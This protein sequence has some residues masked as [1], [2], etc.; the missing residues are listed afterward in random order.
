M[1]SARLPHR[2][3]VSVSGPEARAFLD[4]LLTCD[5]SSAAPGRSTF[6][7]LLSPQGKILADF[8]VHAP[9]PDTF[10]LD[11][12]A[13]CA[14]EL[15]KRLS[16]YRLRAK[17]A[18]E[19]LSSSMAVVA[20]WNGEPEPVVALAV[21]A[22][23]RLAELGWRA[24]VP[25]TDIESAAGSYD[26]HRIAQGVPE[27]GRD[28]AFAD[29]FPHEAMM[30]QLGGVDFSKGCYVGQEVVSRMQHRGTART[31][32]V[33]LVFE[34]GDAPEV[35]VP[36]TAGERALGRMGSS[37]GSRGLATLR[38]DRVA[39]ALAVGETITAAG[40]AARLVKP[41]WV[42]FPFPGEAGASAT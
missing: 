15:V 33:P 42:R 17:L 24:V 18:I 16:L 3:V 13:I 9:E 29:A 30:D 36:V 26:P 23:P 19:D 35:G 12:P 28:F 41:G 7:A 2:A 39:D 34:D 8:I 6:G 31:R 10:W 32:I 38:L 22:D 14:T 11:T 4:R 25:M 1:P 5:L 27:G 20:G 21:S 37:S 40:R